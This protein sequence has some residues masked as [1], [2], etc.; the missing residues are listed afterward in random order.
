VA[1]LLGTTTLLVAIPD[2]RIA[3]AAG[4]L[5]AMIGMVEL[6]RRRIPNRADWGDG[7]AAKE[8]KSYSIK[9]SWT[10]TWRW[11]KLG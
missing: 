6:R 4:V 10:W 9:Y 2:A 3:W 8:K 1:G 7:V 11:T 5:C